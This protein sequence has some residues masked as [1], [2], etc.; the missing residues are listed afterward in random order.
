MASAPAPSHRASLLSGLRTGGVRS[1]SVPSVPYT[2][3]PGALFNIPSRFSSNAYNQHSIGEE[4][5]QLSDMLSHNMYI[6]AQQGF[7]P[8]P[9]TAAVD[10]GANR[11][12]QQQ[13]RFTSG[14]MSHSNAAINNAQLQ[15][16][17]QQQALQMQLMQLELIR[18]QALQAQQLQAELLAQNRQQSGRS[19][20]APATAGPATQSFDINLNTQFRRPSQGELLRSQLGLPSDDQV[21]MTAALGGRF[22]SR[23][24]LP[25][26]VEEDT[27]TL[28]RGNF[29]LTSPTATATGP[30]LG[31]STL[32][33]NVVPPS[34][35]DAAVSW[36]R[37]GNNNSVLSGNRAASLNPGLTT[38]SVRVSPPPQE[39]RGSPPATTDASPARNRPQPLRFTP[40]EPQQLPTVAID[41]TD[42]DD[43]STES[44]FKSGSHST[45]S[46]PNSGS[47]F[48]RPPLSPRE[49]ATKK[50]YEGLGIGR[51]API[52]PTVPAVV[53]Q[54]VLSQ[55]VRQPRGPPSGADELGPRNFATRIRRKAIGGLGALMDARERRDLVEVY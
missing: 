50:L 49:E 16:H 27:A 54:R 13:G 47:S 4:D 21:P 55:P 12:S 35:S 34:K 51:P 3:A 14:L 18:M 8:P 37:G 1:A 5:D 48:D 38:P 33:N 43:N 20:M 17:A 31:T 19:F 10:G 32:N 29:S 9:N 15:V 25:G 46:T 22:G 45:P 2:A 41:D 26:L 28:P 40:I 52:A 11:F 23:S 53:P 42:N 7:Y 44:S 6:N 36:R 39:S 30:S 24:T